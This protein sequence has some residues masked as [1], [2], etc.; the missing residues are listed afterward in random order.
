VA[1]HRSDRVIGPAVGDQRSSLADELP[2]QQQIERVGVD[3]QPVSATAA[4]QPLTGVAGGQTRFDDPA[5]NADGPM[6]R[7][8]RGVRRILP[9]HHIDDLG[10]ADRPA[11]VYQQ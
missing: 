1:R 9:P 5:E 2:E 8:D 11:T 3:V 6:D 10:H 7:V 4:D